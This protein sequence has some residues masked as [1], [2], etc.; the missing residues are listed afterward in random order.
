MCGL[1]E[2]KKK[3][4]LFS[5]ED[6]MC[7]DWVLYVKG[8]KHPHWDVWNVADMRL[9]V[10]EQTHWRLT[11]RDTHVSQLN[12]GSVGRS[13]VLKPLWELTIT[14]QWKASSHSVEKHLCW[15]LCGDVLMWPC[16][17]HG[18]LSPLIH[19]SDHI[20]ANFIYAGAC[21]YTTRGTEWAA[22]CPPP[23]H[24]NP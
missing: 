6:H 1:C 4:E 3:L 19:Y 20:Q 14:L 11:L 21:D 10:G 9:E 17:F 7:S 22:S 18:P 15:C 8:S 13:Y 23:P 2:M 16:E 12:T 5:W 24:W